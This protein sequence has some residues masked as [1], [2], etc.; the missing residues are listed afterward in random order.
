MKKLIDGRKRPRRLVDGG[1]RF[2]S[3]L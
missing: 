2:I 3:T 1:R